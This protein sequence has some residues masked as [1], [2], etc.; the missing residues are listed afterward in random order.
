MIPAAVVVQIPVDSAFVVIPGAVIVGIAVYAAFVVVP[1][2]IVINISI[3]SLRGEGAADHGQ[4]GEPCNSFY[5][6]GSD[7]AAFRRQTCWL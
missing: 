4:A 5:D 6:D 1:D 3:L 7:L 2:A